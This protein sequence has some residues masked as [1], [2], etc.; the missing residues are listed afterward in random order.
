MLRFDYRWMRNGTIRTA[1]SGVSVGGARSRKKGRHREFSYGTIQNLDTSPADALRES[2]L[3]LIRA[4]HERFEAAHPFFW[5]AFP[6]TG[7]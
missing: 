6:V 4:R 2:Q 5:A 3:V 7:R 1:R